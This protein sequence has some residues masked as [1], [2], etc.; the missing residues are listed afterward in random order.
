[1]KPWITFLTIFFFTFTI[2]QAQPNVLK[3]G[4]W[5]GNVELRNATIWA[6]VMPS[7]KTVAVR[8]YPHK[9]LKAANTI[10]YKGILGN[11]FN[12]VKIE[13]NGLEINTAYDYQL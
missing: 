4:P 1:M 11:N 10:Q 7:V 8:Y 13:L 6:E 3:S 5:A 2:I 9:N 12:P